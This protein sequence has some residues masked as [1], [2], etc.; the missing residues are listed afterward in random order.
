MLNTI[1]TPVEK[2]MLAFENFFTSQFKSDIPMLN[3]VLGYVGGSIGKFMRP[4][5]VMLVAKSLGNVNSKT[6]SVAAALEMLHTASLLHDDVVDDSDKRRGKPSLN[7]VYSN[8]IA[9]LAGDYLFS[10]ALNN[11]AVTGDHRLML[12]LSVLGK[13]LSRGEM[14][15]IELQ[16]TGNY[17]EENYLK[18]IKGKT[19]SLFVCSAVCA[20]YSAGADDDV[21]ERFRKFGEYAGICFQIKDDIFDYFSNDVGKPTGKDMLEGKITIPAIYVL[22]KSNNPLLEPIREKLSKAEYLDEKDIEIL[23]GIS[24][25][26]GGVEY[27]GSMIDKYRSLAFEALPDDIPAEL[28][29][30]LSEYVDYI[31]N[32]EK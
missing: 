19:A 21:V 31:V 20:A 27:A 28:R 10:Q 25:E 26:E 30:A 23:I 2:E 18:V 8:S 22:E 4:L 12:E 24:L 14:M 6:Y 16:R 32:R 3:S 5:L 13:A 1:K 29:S 11:V 9:V 15:Q 7:A 17:N